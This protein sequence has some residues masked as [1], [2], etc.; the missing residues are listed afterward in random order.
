ML[1]VDDLVNAVINSYNLDNQN[2]EGNDRDS[3]DNLS[4]VFLKEKRKYFFIVI[5]ELIDIISN[6][7]DKV[8]E[9]FK[10][11][12]KVLDY[13]IIYRVFD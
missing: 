13:L 2:F 1:F 11:K 12:G 6:S 3:E 9:K 10:T 7:C 4:L 8:I 5:E